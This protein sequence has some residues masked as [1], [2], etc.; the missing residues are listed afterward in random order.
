VLTEC[1]VVLLSCAFFR[2]E[3]EHPG[4]R[5]LSTKID[6]PVYVAINTEGVYVIDSDDFVSSVFTCMHRHYHYQA[7]CNSP[8]A[9]E[10]EHCYIRMV[11]FEVVGKKL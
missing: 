1:N 11:S 9:E 8:T 4:R 5:L 7:I 10:L 2:G 6:D 3:V